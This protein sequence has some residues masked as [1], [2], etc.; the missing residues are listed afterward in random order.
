M[1]LQ[2]PDT[3]KMGSLRQKTRQ[4]EA[5]RIYFALFGNP[6]GLV[7]HGSKVTLVVGDLR[8]SDLVVE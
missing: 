2:V 8:I 6:G 1:K 3:P 5:G 7:K 4:P